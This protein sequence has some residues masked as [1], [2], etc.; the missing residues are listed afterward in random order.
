[1]TERLFFSWLL[2][3][4]EK[5]KYRVHKNHIIHIKIY[6]A[7]RIHNNIMNV[8]RKKSMGMKREKSTASIGGIKRM[9]AEKKRRE[10]NSVWSSSR[11]EYNETFPQRSREQIRYTTENVPSCASRINVYFIRCLKKHAKQVIVKAIHSVEL[12]CWWH[13]TKTTMAIAIA[14]MTYLLTCTSRVYLGV[15]NKND[16]ILWCDDWCDNSSRHSPNKQSP[17]TQLN[18]WKGKKNSNHAFNV[19]RWV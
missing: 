5:Q 16:S 11:K 15:R 14:I 4:N 13:P 17:Y 10:W 2:R 1:M 7:N 12:N 19:L 9:E 6:R 18:V 8:K 3:L